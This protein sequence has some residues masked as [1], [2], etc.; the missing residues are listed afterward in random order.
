MHRPVRARRARGVGCCGA[1]FTILAD[2]GAQ[3]FRA[4]Q[5]EIR[6]VLGQQ[7]VLDSNFA[8]RAHS[9]MLCG[10]ILTLLATDAHDIC[11]ARLTGAPVLKITRIA[12]KIA[13]ALANVES[14]AYGGTG[15]TRIVFP[16]LALCKVLTDGTRARLLTS[17]TF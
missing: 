13:A 6:T 16:P 4:R 8:L 9:V 12:L 17:S 5:A 10:T 1:L 14:I 2:I 15:F 11:A 3:G 7:L